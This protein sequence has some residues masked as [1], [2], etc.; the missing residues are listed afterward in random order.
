MKKHR[1]LNCYQLSSQEIIFTNFFSLQVAFLIVDHVDC[2][3]L[4]QD[5]YWEQSFPDTLPYT[6][7]AQKYK[8]DEFVGSAA[9]K[10][11]LKAVFT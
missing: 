7:A 3:E 2:P 11:S 5:A 6:V 9:E 8:K 1:I 4:V 10:L